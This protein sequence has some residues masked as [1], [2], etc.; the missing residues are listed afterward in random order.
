[1]VVSDRMVASSFACGHAF[2]L[3]YTNCDICSVLRISSAFVDCVFP[4][5]LF[6][7]LIFFSVSSL[8]E[9]IVVMSSIC[10]AAV[11]GAFGAAPGRRK[12]RRR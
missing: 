10:G 1:M 9:Y 3:Q 4:F 12:A 6:L 7:S 11:P 8:Y 2:H 5:V